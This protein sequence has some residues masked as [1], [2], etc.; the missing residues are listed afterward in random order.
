MVV[1]SLG[2]KGF[3]QSNRPRG[4]ENRFFPMIGRLLTDEQRMSLLRNMDFDRDQIQ[5]LQEKIRSSRAALLNQIVSGKFDEKLVRQY[6][7]QS[8]GAE[9]QLTVIF[10][11]ALAQMQPPLSAEQLAQL[12]TFQSGRFVGLRDEAETPAPEVHLKL[13]PS[14]PTDT[15]GLPIVN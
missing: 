15:N 13:P 5:P 1:I 14:L 10:A 8:A 12:K 3:A 4:L 6:A 11:R 7:A 9:A 2:P